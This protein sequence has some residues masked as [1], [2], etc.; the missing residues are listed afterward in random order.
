[1][2]IRALTLAAFLLAA[3][4]TVVNDAAMIPVDGAKYWPRGRGP[5]GPCLANDSGYLD[6]RVT[7]ASAQGQYSPQLARALE[8]AEQFYVAIPV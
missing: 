6:E 8:C 1:M 5:S 7:T 3:G 4:H 2:R